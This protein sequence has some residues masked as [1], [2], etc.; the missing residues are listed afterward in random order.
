MNY[1]TTAEIKK[2]IRKAKDEAYSIAKWQAKELARFYPDAHLKAVRRGGFELRYG[3]G[4]DDSHPDQDQDI[5]W[6]GSF[7][8]LSARDLRA[9]VESAY[10]QG[11]DSHIRWIE[12]EVHPKTTW[13]PLD[14]Y[15][16]TGKEHLGKR[17]EVDF[18]EYY[19]YT[20]DQESGNVSLWS[21]R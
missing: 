7:T 3:Y 1:P 4:Y 18:H 14:R 13:I 11:E 6:M 16:E 8:T 12:V 17:E 19:P 2:A 20:A 9:L 5:D 15:G 21:E 10:K